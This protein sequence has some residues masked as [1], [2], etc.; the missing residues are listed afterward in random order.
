M[1]LLSGRRAAATV[2]RLSAR[3]ASFAQLEGRVRKIVNQVRADGDRA[4]RR[5]ANQWD[6]LTSGQPLRVSQ[7]E[8]KS[9]L[10]SLA[11]RLRKAVRCAEENIR[12]FCEWQK[13]SSWTRSNKGTL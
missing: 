13:P 3:G 8:M 6:G 11:P 2:E 12:R 7:G 5:Y 9:A 10:R 4:L 1:Q